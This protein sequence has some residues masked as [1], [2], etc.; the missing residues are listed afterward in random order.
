MNSYNKNYMTQV[1]VKEEYGKYFDF[2]ILFLM[3]LLASG[4][5][6]LLHAASPKKS[7]CTIK[8]KKFELVNCCSISNCKCCRGV[9]YDCQTY[10]NEN[11]GGGSC[12][13]NNE[14]G[15][16]CTREYCRYGSCCLVGVCTMSC[17]SCHLFDILVHVDKKNKDGIMTVKC[18][19]NNENECTTIIDNLLVGSNIT[20]YYNLFEPIF[21]PYLDRTVSDIFI[22][23][24]FIIVVIILVIAAASGYRS[25][26]LL[27]FPTIWLFLVVVLFI[28]T[29]NIPQ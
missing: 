8:N 1:V 19:Y 16:C 24:S 23:I 2:V 10:Y 14:N 15:T 29:I 18:N 5:I 26:I 4:S 11:C 28:L 20:C 7:I 12:A 27:I 9:N 22:M 6:L 13:T 3:I 25:K 17:K 21:Q